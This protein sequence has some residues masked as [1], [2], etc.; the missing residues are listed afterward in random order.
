MIS[1]LTKNRKIIHG[2]CDCF[3]ASVEMRDNPALKGK[4]LAVGGKVDQRGVIA[5]C[6]YEARAFGIRSAMPTIQ[7]KKRCP[8]LVLLP[9]DIPRYREASGQILQIFSEYTKL[10]EPLSLDEAYLDVSGTTLHQG[11]A[12]LIATEIRERVKKEVGITISAGVAP[13]KFLAKVASDWKKPDGLFVISPSDVAQFVS[14]L[15]VSN[16]FGVGKVTAQRLK[17]LG[18]ESCEDLRRFDE[19]KLVH[20]FGRFGLALYQ[21]C[22]GIDNRS[23]VPNRI[24]KSVSVETTFQ[25][26]I[27]PDM[28]AEKVLAKLLSQLYQRFYSLKHHPVLHKYFIKLRFS[29]FSTTTLERTDNRVLQPLLTKEKGGGISQFVMSALPLF[30]YLLIEAAQ[31]KPLPLRLIGLGVRFQET[32]CMEDGLSV[33]STQLSLFSTPELPVLP[34]VK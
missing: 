16:I 10:I 32:A 3:Y 14:L 11:S 27:P 20:H 34:L 24:R 4:P 7:A 22:R 1:E 5:T 21:R 8:D 26:D 28:G 29:D 9:P 19:S 33:R 15:P 13:N 6:N 12:T 2:D 23:V 25:H 17:L 31:R 18:V 30:Q